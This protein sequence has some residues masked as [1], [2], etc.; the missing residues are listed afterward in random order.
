M[1]SRPINYGAGFAP[2]VNMINV[3]VDLGDMLPHGQSQFLYLWEGFNT[4]DSDE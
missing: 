2:Q 4:S 3:N 1:P